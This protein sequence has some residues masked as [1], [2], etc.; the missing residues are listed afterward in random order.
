MPSGEKGSIYLSLD[1]DIETLTD[2]FAADE[3]Q[4]KQIETKSH[5]RCQSA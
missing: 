3:Q 4:K 1:W 2:L 5:T